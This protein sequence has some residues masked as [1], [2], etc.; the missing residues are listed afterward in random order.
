MRANE[1]PAAKI[2]PN[3][4]PPR[5]VG[6]LSKPPTSVTGTAW[7]FTAASKQASRQIYTF[8]VM[9]V[10]H[11]EM[12]QRRKRMQCH[13]QRCGRSLTRSYLETHE[14]KP[15]CLPGPPLPDRSRTD[16]GA[17]L[18]QCRWNCCRCN[19]SLLLAARLRDVLC[20]AGASVPPQDIQNWPVA[21]CVPC[22]KPTW[23]PRRACGPRVDRRCCTALAFRT[24]ITST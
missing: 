3:D 12:S 17:S 4:I 24:G 1:Q 7:P 18:S 19:L 13:S 23:D 15:L 11:R 2:A 20:C 16:I 14:L 22:L 9:E 5:V 21:A 10:W 8:T 6:A